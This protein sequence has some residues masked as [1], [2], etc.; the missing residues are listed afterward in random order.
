[1]KIRTL[2]FISTAVSL[3]AATSVQAAFITGV[4]D[5]SY[6]ID[7]TDFNLTSLGS[8]DWAYWDS[9]TSASTNSKSGADLISGVSIV[10]SGALANSSSANAAL[11]FSFTDGVS[12][13][14]ESALGSI[15]G[16]FSNNYDNTVAEGLQF[17]V[18]L[19]T[20]EV[21]ELRIWGGAFRS[22]EYDLT[23]TMAGADPLT[24]SR[25]Y[26]GNDLQTNYYTFQLQADS[27]DTDATISLLDLDFSTAV[28]GEGVRLYGVSLATIPEPNAALAV[29]LFVVASVVMCRRKKC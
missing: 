15:G 4:G 16:V 2:A 20:T 28:A 23:I 14:S 17:S 26:S 8:S 9:A 24:T 25:T 7:L 18:T 22:G 27:A 10:G 11:T 12:P 5:P 13:V 1:M 3:V 21:Y 6:D 19:P 29:G